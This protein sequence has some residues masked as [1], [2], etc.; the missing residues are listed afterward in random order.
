MKIKFL[1]LFTVLC[2]SFQV[3]SAQTEKQ[4]TAIRGEVAAI[5]KN[6]AKYKKVKK[7][8]DG[9]SLEGTEATYY[10]S[11]KGFKKV[12]AN[13]YGETFKATGEF[14]YSGDEIIFAYIKSHL[15]DT[16]IGLSTPVK[17]VKITEERYYFSGGEIIRI[18]DG[19]KLLKSTA[20][21][22]IELKEGIV[23]INAVLKEG[24]LK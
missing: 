13:M 20:E 18:I 15:Y 12:V 10:T 9:V 6:A 19:K 11:G 2:F 7:D 24:F 17:V 22:F 16:Q 23:S 1:M 8:V 21:K 3:V 4:I 14:Y 5:N